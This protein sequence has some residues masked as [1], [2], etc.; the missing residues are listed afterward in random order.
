MMNFKIKNIEISNLRNIP[1]D[2][3]LYFD[4]SEQMITIFDGPNWLWKNNFF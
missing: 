4:L 1:F 2:S 3:P